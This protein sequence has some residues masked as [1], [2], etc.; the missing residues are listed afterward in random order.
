MRLSQ[1]ILAL[2]FCGFIADASAD[3]ESPAPRSNDVV[4]RIKLAVAY[5]K[6]HGRKKA[7]IEF[8]D[9]KSPFNQG[10]IYIFGVLFDEDGTEPIHPNPN[11][12]GKKMIG[13][14]D[15]DGRFLIRAMV[16]ICANY[17]KGW[18]DYKWPNPETSSI[19]RK[20]TYV[21]KAGDICLGAGTFTP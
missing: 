14:Q 4:K 10:G 6:K 7:T 15:S 9:P 11:I 16:D 3:H 20:T 8:N 2:F 21:E 17:G 5:V 13:L 12:R 1:F 18:I 19:E